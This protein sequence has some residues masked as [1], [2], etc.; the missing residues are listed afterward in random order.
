M[1]LQ[2]DRACTPTEDGVIHGLW[3]FSR[4]VQTC[5]LPVAIR[6]ALPLGLGCY[7]VCAVLLFDDG[8]SACVCACVGTMCMELSCVCDDTI[9]VQCT[10]DFSV[11]TCG[12]Y[13]RR[14]TSPVSQ[15]FLAKISG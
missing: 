5:G 1:L 13:G 11:C 2:H 9:C 3:H 8:V 15:V 14:M 6:A 7:A 12:I 4:S 10:C